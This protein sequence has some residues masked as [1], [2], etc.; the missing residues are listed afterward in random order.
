VTH[1]GPPAQRAELAHSA[2]FL[3]PALGLFETLLGCRFPFPAF[4]QARA[5]A[6]P[7]AGPARRAA[8][9]PLT[10]QPAHASPPPRGEAPRGAAG[11][12][13]SGAR[14]D[15]SPRA[16]RPLVLDAGSAQGIRIA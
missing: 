8:P 9:G 14:P 4:H 11:D 2:A 6:G 15:P 10:L 12:R 7:A 5:R 13:A 16:C 1:L 3:P